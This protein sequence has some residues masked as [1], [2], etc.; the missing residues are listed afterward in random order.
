MH[1][2][3]AQD[4][5]NTYINNK[6]VNERNQAIRELADNKTVFWLDENEVFDDSNGKLASEYTSDGVHIKASCVPIW[7]KFLL[8]NAVKR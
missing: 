6:T 5:K 4:N 7:E 1:V 2:S 3:Q 8:D